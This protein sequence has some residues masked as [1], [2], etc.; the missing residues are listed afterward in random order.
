MTGW[1]R[2]A[3]LIMGGRGVLRAVWGAGGMVRGWRS[4]LIVEEGE[5]V[6]LSYYGGP[7]WDKDLMRRSAT[8]C[9]SN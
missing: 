5:R 1:E 7:G 3:V 8:Q 9:V 2:A 6:T 4:L